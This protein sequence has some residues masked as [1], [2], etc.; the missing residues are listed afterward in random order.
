MKYY[1]DLIKKRIGL[2][3]LVLSVFYVEN[4]FAQISG[5]EQ[6]REHLKKG[7][8]FKAEIFHT[9]VDSFTGD[10]LISSGDVWI[11]QNGYRLIMDDRIIAV[12]DTT[13]MVYNTIKDQIIISNYSP[14]DDDFA[15]SRFI[16]SS[17]TDFIIQEKKLKDGWSIEFVA[18]DEF[19]VFTQIVMSLDAKARPIKLVA[20]DQNGNENGSEFKKVA[21]VSFSKEIKEISYPKTAEVIDLRQ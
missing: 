7:Q 10:T 14:N 13:S 21:F 16:Q 17:K 19:A 1:V 6:L 12:F 4:A 3:L 18:K 20:R 5:L 15:P 9:F 11:H 2:A 8:V